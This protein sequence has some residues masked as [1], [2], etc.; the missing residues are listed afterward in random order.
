VV[1]VPNLRH[2]P[3]AL[4][5]LTAGKDVLLEKPMAMNVAECDQ[6][7]AALKAA[8]R[9][10]LQVNFVSRQAPSSVA[11]RDLIQAGRLGTI[12]HIKAMMYRRRG[13][14]GL[15]RWFTTKAESGGG[16]LIDLGVHLIDLAMYLAG[17][18][19]PTRVSA[20]CTGMFGR[21]IE[22]YAFTEMWAGPPNKQGVFDV[23]DAAT[24][25]IRFQSNLT[26]ELNTTW[27]ANIPDE[28]LPSGMLILGDKGGVFFDI[29]GKRVSLA[30]EESG[31][32]VDIKP[33]MAPGEAWAAGWK[34]QHELFAQA[35]RDRTAPVATAEHGRTVQAVIDAMYRSSDLGREVEV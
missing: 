12:Y 2:K 30:T 13:I 9:R 8:S 35:V 21:P 20:S 25:L 31:Y 3:L 10:I 4:A 34:R 23:D 17:H 6:I 15:G 14:P 24:G 7:I 33:Q 32:L 11:V 16:V 5:A 19:R 1:A 28:T 18:P 27:A 26:L 29:W 22:K